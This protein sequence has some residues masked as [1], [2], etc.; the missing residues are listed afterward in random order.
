MSTNNSAV[1]TRSYRLPKTATP[2]FYDIRITPDLAG[3]TFVGEQTVA[4]EIHEPVNELTFNAAE[5]NISHAVLSDDTG[6]KLVGTV[7]HDE[8]SER[9]TVHFDGTAGGGHWD[10]ELKFT[11]ILNN[12]LKGFYRSTYKNAQGQDEAIATTKFEPC[13]AR[14][15][16]PC[17]DEPAFKARFKISLVINNDLNAISNARLINT[18]DLK[19]GKKLLEFAP[20]IKMSTYL[21]A[22]VVGKL[23]ASAPIIADG[24]EV[25]VWSVPGKAHLHSFALEAAKYSLEYFADYFQQHY[26]GDKLDLVAIPDFASGAMENFGC[27]T[28]RETALLVDTKTASH[29]ELERV[30]EVVF[31]E[32]AHMWFGDF[33]TMFW[34]NGLWLNE[35]FANFM[36]AKGLAAWKPEWKF[37]DGF[38]ISRAGAMRVDGLVATRSIEFPVNNPEEARQMF[39]VLTYDKGCAVLRMLEL[40]LGEDN[41][42]KGIVNYVAKHQFDNADTPDLWSAIEEIVARF[43]DSITVSDL[44]NSWI[45]QAGYPV[46]SVEES[47]VSGSITFKQQMFRYLEG[48]TNNTK[49][50]VPVHLRATVDGA[51]IEKVILLSDAEQS[52]YIGE[53]ISALTVNAGGHG[54]YRVQYSDSLRSKLVSNLGTLSAGERFNFVN[55]LWASVQSGQTSVKDYLS[56]V[57]TLTGKF[58]ETDVNVF[59]IILGSLGTLRRVLSK[60]QSVRAGLLKVARNLIMPALNSIGSEAKAGEDSLTAQLRGSLLLTLGQ[61]GD[62]D[63]LKRM[64]GL[65][66][67]YKTN[68]SAVDSNLVG[69]M[70]ETLASNGDDSVYA[71]FAALKANAA[72]PQ[73][74]QRFLMALASFPQS[75]LTEKTLKSALDGQVRTQDAPSLVVGVML[76]PHASRQA[77]EFVKANWDAM[78]AAYPM[79]GVSRMCSGITALVAPDLE[80][81]VRQF[82]ATHVVKGGDKAVKQYI[83]QLSIA[84]R[85]AQREQAAVETLLTA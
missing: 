80:S 73:E 77:W 55:D 70:V 31:H 81:D 76:N 39:D 15:A 41:F 49:W 82:F 50:H 48:D 38:N 14:R 24:K 84:V 72:T 74:E 35:A 6:T 45:F 57:E 19:N 28:F 51:E 12:K 68:K 8:A 23:E 58:G 52:F 61:L 37:W 44:M 65:F 7:T 21:V 79:Q 85:L 9:V 64:Q 53:N 4:L 17:W 16:F 67:Q 83:E 34:W 40:F 10:L 29:A 78:V 20:T 3:A 13:D 18:T 30:A 1:E 47:A 54:F 36:A 66:G 69:A 22:Y 62:P 42:R 32:N 60:E 26:P 43:S 59:S 27:I 56:A 2:S 11:G 75:E 5:L 46:I 25:R 33:V 71:E 63:V